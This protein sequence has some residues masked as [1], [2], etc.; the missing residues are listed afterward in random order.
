MDRD[1]HFECY[2]CEVSVEK[3][4]SLAGSC[5]VWEKWQ[6]LQPVPSLSDLSFLESVAFLI[7]TPTRAVVGD[8]LTV[9]DCLPISAVV[10]TPGVQGRHFSLISSLGIRPLHSPFLPVTS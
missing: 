7:S 10:A 3:A 6:V 9:G 5:R 8:L 4:V 1:Y 2:H